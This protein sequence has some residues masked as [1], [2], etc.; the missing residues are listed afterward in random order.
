MRR[1]VMLLVFILAASVAHAGDF[2]IMGRDY[3][4]LDWAQNPIGIGVCS[5][6]DDDY[7]FEPGLYGQFAL[8]SWRD[9]V[10][11]NMGC[12][13]IWDYDN[14][15]VDFAPVTSVTMG[16]FFFKANKLMEVGVYYAPFWGL[17]SRSDDPYGLM[18]G[19]AF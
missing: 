3:N 1:I 13:F 4:P 2:K 14:D 17:D 9:A 19:Y 10:R 6:T 11:L 5:W 7:D 8:V 12:A 18:I 15:R 16:I